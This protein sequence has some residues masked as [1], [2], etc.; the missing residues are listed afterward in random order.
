VLRKVVLAMAKQLRCKKCK[1][2]HISVQAVNEVKEVKKKGCGYWLFIGWWLEPI[3]LIL[4]GFW[5]LLHI[6]VGKHTKITSNTKSYAIC[7]DCW[8]RWEVK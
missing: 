3:E 6:V 7:Q 4:F 5:K 1:S 2:Y 8:Y